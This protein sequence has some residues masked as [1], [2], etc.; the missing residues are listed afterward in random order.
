MAEPEPIAEEEGPREEPK[1]EGPRPPGAWAR[2]PYLVLFVV[3]FELS[4]AVMYFVLVVQF[5]LRVTTGHA[6]ERLRGFG[7]HLGRYVRDI[8]AF[9]TY[10]SDAMPF[11]F[12]PWPKD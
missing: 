9:L 8:V 11:P 2:L 3:A 12:A 7:G 5:L 6:N 1:P 10:E 4:K